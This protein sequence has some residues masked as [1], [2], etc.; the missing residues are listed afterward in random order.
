MNQATKIITLI[1]A[2][3]G[4][5]SA[6]GL[7]TGINK[8]RQGMSWDD[9]RTMDKGVTQIVICGAMLVAVGG[10]VAYAITQLHA[11]TF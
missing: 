6:I 8:V 9:D 4:V 11:I 1:G 5:A 10:L 3:I 7:V 2:A